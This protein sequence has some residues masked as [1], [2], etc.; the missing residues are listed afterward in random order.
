VATTQ[1][2][3]ELPEALFEQAQ[4]LAQQLNLSESQLFTWAMESFISS[5]DQQ[6][7]E[8]SN[9]NASTAP[10]R[11]INQGDIYWV[12]L[13]PAQI[14]GVHSATAHPYVVIQDNLFNHS[15]VHSVIA[16]ALTSNIRRIS[17]TPGNVLLEA[18]EANLPK[19]SVVEVSKVS[20][21][22]KRRLGEYIGTLSAQRVNEILTGMRF[23]H[24]SFINR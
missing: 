10:H 11:V 23:L 13:E 6:L 8:R 17:E 24:T 9:V 16:C 21:I 3:I 7:G 5:F 19:K 15:R 1:V 4:R 2:S 12:E 18:G 14:G 22:D 20:A